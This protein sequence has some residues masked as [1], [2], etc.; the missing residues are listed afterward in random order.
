MSSTLEELYFALVVLRS[1]ADRLERAD[2]SWQKRA[3][4]RAV[5]ITAAL[6]L[7]RVDWRDEVDGAL[8]HALKLVDRALSAGD[9]H[10]I[11]EFRDLVERL[12]HL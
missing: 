11:D 8:D 2:A 1:T 10:L 9:E 6:R 3:A 12:E 7:E 4:F 5:N